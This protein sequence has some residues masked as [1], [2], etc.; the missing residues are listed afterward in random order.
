MPAKEKEMMTIA[1]AT[2]RSLSSSIDLLKEAG[3]GFSGLHKMGRSLISEDN[4]RKI[5]YILTKPIDLPTYVEYG[6]ADVGIVGKDVLM[7]QGR[8]LY[9]LLDLKIN[10]CRL[11][12]AKKEGLKKRT[13]IL[14]ATKYPSIVE[15]HFMR[16]GKQ[17]E[18]IKLHGAIELAPLLDM[19]DLIVDLVSTGRTLKEN[20]LVEIEEIMPVSSRLVANRGSYQFKSTRIND[21]VSSLRCALE[22]RETERK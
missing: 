14:V 17:V 10:F 6:A 21:L 11:V 20:N 9:E 22:R 7:E 1:L 13:H 5:R 8:D 15:G 18:T 2:G 16:Q 19:A 4:A 3:Y 12:V